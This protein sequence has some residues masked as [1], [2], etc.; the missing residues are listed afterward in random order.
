[1]EPIQGEGGIIIPEDSYL[2]EVK[3]VCA[4]RNILMIIDEIQT[5][6]GRTGHF[7]ASE[8][9]GLSYDIL[10]LGKGLAG[11]MPVGAT[12]IS[13]SIAQKIS[14]GIH[15]STFGGN[16]LATMGILA[17]LDLLTDDLLNHI[18]KTGEYFLDRLRSIESELIS[19][20][21]GRGLMIGVK[22]KGNRDKIQQ[23][24]Q[25]ELILAAPAA[26]NVIRFLP[27][28]IIDRKHIDQVADT[29]KKV[30]SDLGE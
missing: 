26:H 6:N 18:Q 14:K 4:S 11:G 21:K 23:C 2:K 15:T 1:V 13:R 16:P 8:Q 12:L 30:L 29:L 3:E 17:T 9:D 22:V 27:P 20:I 28:Y 7:L 19:Q 25:K 24:L 10:C 5:G